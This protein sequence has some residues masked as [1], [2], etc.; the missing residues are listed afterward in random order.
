MEELRQIEEA[1]EI[2]ATTERAVISCMIMDNA[3]AERCLLILSKNDFVDPDCIRIFSAIKVVHQSGGYIDLQ[4]VCA[5][6]EPD[7]TMKVVSVASELPTSANVDYYIK[8][9]QQASRNRRFVS[10]FTAIVERAKSGDDG[11]LSK[12]Q[13]VLNELSKGVESG[14]RL[15]R[16]F[17]P[18]AINKLG[19]QDKGIPTGFYDLDD[20]IRGLCKGDL[21]IVAGR[22]SMGK[23]S[24]AA[25]I[26]TNVAKD[27]HVVAYFSLEMTSVSI[28]QRMIYGLTNHSE[29]EIVS[30]MKSDNPVI[31]GKVFEAGQEIEPMK[32]YLNESSSVSVSKIALECKKLMT[33]EGTLDLVVIDYLGLIQ[34]D[35]FGGSGKTRPQEVAEISHA[36]KRLAKDLDCP[37]ILVSQLNRNSEA[38]SDHTPML[39]DLSESGAVEADADV[40]LFPFRPWVYDREIE[41]SEAELIIAKNR[42]GAVKKIPLY[43]KG[44]LFMFKSVARNG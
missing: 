20:S 15:A 13:D 18:E 11:F 37:I 29:N 9:L 36:L 10:E 30:D 8:E 17:V 33:L 4:S 34:T 24:F 19:S 22:P 32:L 35:G 41:P 38:R 27:G 26:A 21:I 7:F 14:M 23:S 3:C 40:I 43:W 5:V 31:T 44:D 25:N 1:G 16:D 2:N 42:N 12:A 6:L 28:V 39:S